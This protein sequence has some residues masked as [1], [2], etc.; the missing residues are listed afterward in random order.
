[1]GHA[2]GPA[3]RVLSVEQDETDTQTE[4]VLARPGRPDAVHHTKERDDQGAITDQKASQRIVPILLGATGARLAGR[5]GGSLELDLVLT[6]RVL[7][8]SDT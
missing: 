7:R 3:Q 6:G 1:M 8:R 4:T 2:S 5:P